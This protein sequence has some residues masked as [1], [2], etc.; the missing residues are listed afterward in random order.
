[1]GRTRVH[2]ALGALLALAGAALVSSSAPAAQAWPGELPA[3]AASRQVK[4]P[5]IEFDPIPFGH[6]RKRQMAAYSKRHYG[7]RTWRLTDPKAIV[8]HYTATDTYPPVFNTFASNAP[9]LGESPGVCAQ[10]V[11]DKDGT[12]HQLTRLYVRCR[13]TV[14]LNHVAL[15]IEMVQGATGTRH[16]AEQAILGRRGQARSAVRLV[17][18][19]KQR[20]GIDMKNVIG[21]AMANDS[22]LFKDREGWRNDHVDWRSTDVRQFRKRVAKLIRASRG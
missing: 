2:L 13:H 21:H 12:I 3:L 6:D 4:E 5:K 19:L 1:M 17:A 8:L 7:E 9:N 20:Y 10:F 18:W 15:G 22:P 11:V 14:G 16:G